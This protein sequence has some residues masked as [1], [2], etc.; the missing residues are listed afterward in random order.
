MRLQLVIRLQHF[1]SVI[2]QWIEVGWI[3]DH[4]VLAMKLR[5]FDLM[6]LETKNVKTMGTSRKINAVLL[7][8]NINRPKLENMCG[9][10]LSTYWQN[11]TEIHINLS[12]NIAKSF[13]GL[14]FWLTLYTRIC[15]FWTKELNIL[16]VPPPQTPPR[17]VGQ[18][19][20]TLWSDRV[21]RFEKKFAECDNIFC[22]IS[23]YVR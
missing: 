14:L 13:R 15:H 4:S 12:E 23:V 9:Y 17:L 22:K 19:S 21:R 5:R 7:N 6:T 10:K 18:T 20:S 8:I 1:R 3:G 2:I 11:F 16:G